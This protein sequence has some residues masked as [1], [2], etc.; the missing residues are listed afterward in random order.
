MG[1]LTAPPQ[2]RLASSGAAPNWL[3]SQPIDT[4]APPA[5]PQTET[6]LESAVQRASVTTIE[7][8]EEGNLR[9]APA[10]RPI[11]IEGPRLRVTSSGPDRVSLGKSARYEIV[12][13]NLESHRA[14]NLIVGI[15]FPEWVEITNVSPS[16]GSREMTSGEEEARIVWQIPIV[17]PASTEKITLDV[18]PREARAFEVNVEWTFRPLQGS[19]MVEV[20]Q[21]QLMIQMSGPTEVMYGE[22]AL[23]HV[24]V[25]N[26]GTGT[27][28][29]VMV[30]LPEILGGER[31]T[32][33]NIEPQEQKQFQVELV[34]RT[35]GPL[36]L[37]TTVTADSELSETVKREIVVR[38]AELEM[39]IEGPPM[40]YAGTRATYQVTVANRGDAMARDVVAAVAL[41]A[42]MQFVSGIEGAEQID[43]G[44]RWNVGMLSPGNHRT[45]QIECQLDTAGDMTVEVAARGAA[46][47]AATN[48]ITTRV[49][50][51]ADLVLSVADPK[52]PLPVGEQVPYEITVRNRGTR[53]AENVNIVLHFSEGVEPVQAEGLGH[54]IAP[55]QVTFNPVARID[56]GQEVVIKVIASANKAGS[57]LFRAQVLCEESDLHEVAEGTTKFFGEPAAAD[58]E[59]PGPETDSTFRR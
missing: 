44:L 42:G 49:D 40:K 53:S 48:S 26:P 52:G 41:P 58:N 22:K 39:I 29:N 4:V 57:H 32:L 10:G 31:A 17:E 2:E 5:A 7:T 45:W 55:G 59:A 21:P 27:A 36:D 25:S 56:P 15:D 6:E 11:N 9:T 3:R 8:L 37:I 51:V 35:A 30:M 54:E 13:E 1:T 28:E 23:Y 38:R 50:A 20:T 14:E 34:A 43:G 46:D 47:L 16:N 33:G 24:T 18:T 19:A 12:V